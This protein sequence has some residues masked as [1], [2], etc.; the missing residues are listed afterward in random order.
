[1]KK[2]IVLFIA[3]FSFGM[4]SAQSTSDSTIRMYNTLTGIRFVQNQ[5]EVYRAD[6]Y[7]MLSTM[8]L[9]KLYIYKASL[10]ESMSLLFGLG[11]GFFIG[12]PL[13][14]KLSGKE[15]NWEF[16]GGGILMLLVAAHFNVAYKNNMAL[17][18][19]IYNVSYGLIFNVKCLKS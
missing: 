19:S 10:N 11:G 14:Q 3:I 5:Q 7:D 17:A 15:P 16:A 1:M 4:L 12:Y 18:I 8:N 6:V 13:G 9:S 2:L